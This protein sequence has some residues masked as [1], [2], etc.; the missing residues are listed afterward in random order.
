M[1]EIED[2]D[3]QQVAAVTSPADLDYWAERLAT[4]PGLRGP[5][6]PLEIATYAMRRMS[7]PQMPYLGSS[8]REVIGS[9]V[10]ARVTQGRLV[11]TSVLA[12]LRWARGQELTARP[13]QIAG[14]VARPAASLELGGQTTIPQ[15]P[16]RVGD[17]G[18]V[19]IPA[20]IRAWLD[21]VDGSEVTVVALPRRRQAVLL[22]WS[23][24][25]SMLGEPLGEQ[26]EPSW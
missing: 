25:A 23:S 9:V 3:P 15:Q 5:I 11:M 2:P 17:R 26:L 12:S 21:V 16:T 1:G 22:P 4:P 14:D 19:L 10:T 13:M 8:H 18:R 24:L 20:S 6:E 7:G